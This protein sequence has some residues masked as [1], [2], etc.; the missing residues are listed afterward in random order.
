[1]M[2]P[3]QLPMGLS[4]HP[5]FKQVS[6]MASVTLFTS[7]LAKASLWNPLLSSTLSRSKQNPFIFFLRRDPQFW[8]DDLITYHLKTKHPHLSRLN[9]ILPKQDWSQGE[10][11][12]QLLEVGAGAQPGS[13]PPALLLESR[14]PP[15]TSSL[16]LQVDHLL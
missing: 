12:S 7:F 2:P 9:P 5:C 3:L 8:V 4:P 15:T 11:C 1:M 6:S 13:K 10:G 14:F 16:G